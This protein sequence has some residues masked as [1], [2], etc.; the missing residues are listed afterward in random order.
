MTTEQIIKKKLKDTTKCKF[1]QAWFPK[2]WTAV[3]IA[4]FSKELAKE[5]RR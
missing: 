4:K 1:K 2:G 3:N 5:L